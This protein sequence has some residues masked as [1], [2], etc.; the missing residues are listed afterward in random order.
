MHGV[1]RLQAALT[2]ET[3]DAVL[4]YVN[5]ESER[6]KAAVEAGEVDFG[7]YFGGVNCRGMNGL[8]GN[9]Q[10]MFL[11][12]SDPTVRHTNASRNTARRAGRT[13]GEQRELLRAENTPEWL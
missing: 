7:A 11:P 5:G 3:C 6:A 1:A 8:F 13:H 10:D 9:R 4:Q 12:M 2:P